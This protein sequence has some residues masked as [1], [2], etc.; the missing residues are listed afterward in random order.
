MNKSQVT[1]LTAALIVTAG[2]LIAFYVNPVAGEH[3]KTVGFFALS[4]AITNW[5]AIY[6][7]FEKVPGLYGSGVIPAHFSEI[8]DW[9]HNMVMEQFFTHENLD[10]YFKEGQDMLFKSVDLDAAVDQLD[11]DRIYDTVK[12]EILSSKLGGMLG[13]FGGEGLFERYRDPF[14][15]KMR[16]HILLE[17]SAPGFFQSILSSGNIDI[18]SIVMEKV[19]VIIQERL[20]DLTPQMIKEIVQEMIKR[21]LGWLVV[22][23]GVFGGLIGLVMS[24]VN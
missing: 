16:E 17:L 8:K 11:Y 2:Y 13:M 23:G 19:E 12:A 18:S 24:F 7:L 20:D 3:I 9:I 5:L 22:W 6:M 21:H 10:H 4:G 15:L 1:N 14:K